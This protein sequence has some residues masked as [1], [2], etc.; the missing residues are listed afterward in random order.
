MDLTAVSLENLL[1][2][3]TQIS[4]SVIG[5]TPVLKYFEQY[6]L[7]GYY[8]YYKDAGEDYLMRIGEVAR[9]T[10][11]SDVPSLEPVSVQTVQKMKHLLMVI[12][13][14]IPMEINVNKLTSQLETTRD[15][16][17]K[18]LYLLDRAGLLHLLTEQN[19]D[20]KHLSGPKKIYLDNTNLMAALHPTPSAGMIRE[21]FFAN[22][23]GTVGSLTMPKQGD[24]KVNGQWLFEVGGQG[25]TFKQIADI[26][27]S[28]LA[29]DDIESGT[30]ARIPLWMFGLLY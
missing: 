6:L 12:A 30:G 14:S 20:Y 29:V 25:K 15:Q 5:K 8:P 4:L 16:C 28:Y 26:P 19:K 9:L 18:M 21:T 24:F 3:H 17:L 22:Q 1:A 7:N 23:M 13:A 2:N 11:E 10:I 27:N